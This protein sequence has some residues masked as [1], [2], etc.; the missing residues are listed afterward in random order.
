MGLRPNWSNSLSV[1]PKWPQ[2]EQS[3]QREKTNPDG[4]SRSPPCPPCL[5]PCGWEY[6][7]QALLWPWHLLWGHDALCWQVV[8]LLWEVAKKNIW[9][10]GKLEEMGPKKC[11]GLFN[12]VHIMMSR[13]TEKWLCCR[14]T[15]GC[16]VPTWA[17]LQWWYYH[18]KDSVFGWD[19]V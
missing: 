8:Q 11:F 9:V 3:S 12:I 4:G 18:L 19:Q 1:W 10:L 5:P 14:W 13:W 7:L 16:R 15:T 6:L 17:N 2:L